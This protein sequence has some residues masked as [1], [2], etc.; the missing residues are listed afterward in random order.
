MCTS[1]DVRRCVATRC[2]AQVEALKRFTA[3]SVRDMPVTAVR[4]DLYAGR[5]GCIVP[6]PSC[7]LRTAR[8]SD[9]CTVRR[10][11]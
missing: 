9:T 7:S 2:S 5:H 4:I 3:E 10:K 6:D 11:L 8:S 1:C